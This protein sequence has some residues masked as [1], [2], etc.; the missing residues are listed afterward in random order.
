MSQV[1]QRLK[2]IYVDLC[3]NVMCDLSC[4]VFNISSFKSF[5]ISL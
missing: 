2:V 5:S 1:Q 4:V 3:Q